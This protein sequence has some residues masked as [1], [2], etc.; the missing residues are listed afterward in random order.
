ML[1]HS[2]RGS[3]Y[4]SCDYQAYLKSHGFICRMSCKGDCWDNAPMEAFWG[5]MKTFYN[6]QRIH[7]SNGYLTPEAYYQSAS[8]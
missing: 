2:D 4:C 3:Q 8:N 5:K 1:T 7:Q 6:R